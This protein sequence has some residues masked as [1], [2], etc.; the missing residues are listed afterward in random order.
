[1][2]RVEDCFSLVNG[3]C[4][5]ALSCSLRRW[6]DRDIPTRSSR[7]SVREVTIGHGSRQA[8]NIDYYIRCS[9][10]LFPFAFFISHLIPTSLHMT[11]L[12]RSPHERFVRRLEDFLLRTTLF[13][14]RQLNSA[15][16]IEDFALV[17]RRAQKEVAVMT[18]LVRTSLQ[19]CDVSKWRF[20]CSSW[21]GKLSPDVTPSDRE[22]MTR[23]IGASVSI[24]VFAIASN[25]LFTLT[26]P[27]QYAVVFS[28]AVTSI[29]LTY[30]VC[31]LVGYY[32]VSPADFEVCPLSAISYSNCS[33][34]NRL[35]LVTSMVP[36]FYGRCLVGF[37]P[38]F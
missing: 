34:V 3:A 10:I 7:L 8:L 6:C 16:T 5:D 1:M 30:S 23:V 13:P 35:V 31:W 9:T 12:Q 37:L 36:S 17:L 15:T 19:H 32:W 28:A 33:D 25:S 24:A 2:R 21:Q 20:S 22:W 38:F 29:G 14:A 26:N 18:T 27:A 11:S 4:D